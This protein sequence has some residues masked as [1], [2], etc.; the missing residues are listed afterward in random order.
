MVNFTMRAL[1]ASVLVIGSIVVRA[2]GPAKY[3]YLPQPGIGG[4]D[5]QKPD[6]LPYCVFCSYVTGTYD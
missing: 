5:W 1:M 2:S 6:E 4:H 3:A